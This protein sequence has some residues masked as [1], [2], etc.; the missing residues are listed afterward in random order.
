[1]TSNASSI[2]SVLAQTIEQLSYSMDAH[3]RRSVEES[4]LANL[5][6][7]QIHYLDMIRHMGNP[8][9]GELAERMGVRRPT[10][11]MAVSDLTKA[12]Y[13]QK[14]RNPGD[15]RSVLVSL[16]RQGQAVAE[17][18]DEIHAGYANLLASALGE[19]DAARLESLLRRALRTIDIGT[20]AEGE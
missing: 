19:R 16:T 18:H 9:V 10:A 11:T 12:G 15:R 3:E 17:L 6:S 4:R 13:L 1:M 14:G 8:Q 20:E 2:V 7:T 5:S